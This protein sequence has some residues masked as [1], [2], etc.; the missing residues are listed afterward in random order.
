M[1]TTHTVHYSRK[2]K[3]NTVRFSNA[4]GVYEQRFSSTL[5]SLQRCGQCHCVVTLG[6]TSER[7]ILRPELP[8]NGSRFFSVTLLSEFSLLVARQ[9]LGTI[10][11][12]LI[13]FIFLAA[14]A[15]VFINYIS[16]I[17]LIQSSS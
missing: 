5:F 13:P 16:Q 10:R 9:K 3:G 14:T 7:N 15:S 17:S 2:P 6:S 1:I 11:V 4:L 8:G 12:K